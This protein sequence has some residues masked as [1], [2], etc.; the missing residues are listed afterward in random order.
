ME[1]ID[2]DAVPAGADPVWQPPFWISGAP[3]TML[4]VMWHAWFR[5][6]LEDPA[7]RALKD[8]LIFGVGVLRVPA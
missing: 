1:R 8:V 6:H 4:A 2:D 7:L 5:D 3:T